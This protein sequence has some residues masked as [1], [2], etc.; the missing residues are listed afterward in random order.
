[1]GRGPLKHVQRADS[2]FQENI[3]C[4]LSEITQEKTVTKYCKT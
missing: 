3:V 2:V 4:G 1:M